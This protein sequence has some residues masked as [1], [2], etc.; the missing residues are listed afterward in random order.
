MI[1][2]LFF[3][4]FFCLF[5]NLDAQQLKTRELYP[6]VQLHQG[7]YQQAFDTLQQL[8]LNAQKSNYF[9]AQIEAAIHLGLYQEAL[10]V[11]NKLEKIEKNASTAYQT[12]LFLK[13]NDYPSAQNALLKN[14]QSDC[15]ISLFDLFN[16]KDFEKLM[17]TPFI[18][19]ILKTQFYS[20][21]EKQIFRV[22]Q[23]YG[24]GKFTEALFLVQEIISRNHNLHQAFYLH[25]KIS[26]ALKDQKKAI[27]TINKA[28]EITKV[29]VEY[30]YQR[31]ILHQKMGDYKSALADI[32]KVIYKD[33]YHAGYYLLKAELLFEAGKYSESKSLADALVTLMPK[34]ADLLIVKAKS[35]FHDKQLM[36]ALVTINESF[37]KR[38]S[39]EQ[40][41]LRG[42]IYAATGTW[43]YALR[44]YS[45][46]LDFDPYNGNIYAKKGYARLK[47]GDIK[48]ACYDWSKGKRYG[49]IDAIK[50]WDK[51]CN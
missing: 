37:E 38:E 49:S 27:E 9:L 47:T 43:E 48:G 32:E 10:E 13:L 1:R 25:S 23:L 11:C 39:K 28:I 15:K 7:N 3:I 34:N 36:Q 20:T 29:P 16:D 42:D 19:S 18:D 51:Y 8:S 12:K 14:L 44:D 45:M 21:T 17:H 2:L 4:G 22:E 30:F 40:F 31:A 5:T 33:P 6:F 50:Y 41:E 26:I 46:V 24:Q 35:L